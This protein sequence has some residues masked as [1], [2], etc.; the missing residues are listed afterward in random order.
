M[1]VI[2]GAVGKALLALNYVDRLKDVLIVESKELSLSKLV[3]KDGVYVLQLDNNSVE[4][5]KEAL[6]V[7][8]IGL[9]EEAEPN[10]TILFY[11][12]TTLECLP[13]IQEF[14]KKFN[15]DVIVTL[16]TNGSVGEFTI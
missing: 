5:T 16:Q 1:K 10:F 11:L 13:M 9:N 6:N 15:L 7:L 14:E 2:Y 8:S 3:S 12:N 4:E